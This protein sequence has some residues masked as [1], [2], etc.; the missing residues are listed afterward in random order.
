[1]LQS[2]RNIRQGKQIRPNEAKMNSIN[3]IFMKRN[4]SYIDLG[5]LSNQKGKYS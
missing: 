3:P 1:M 2:K 4:P 5:A